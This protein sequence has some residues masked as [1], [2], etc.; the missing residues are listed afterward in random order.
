MKVTRR[1][2]MRAHLFTHLYRYVMGPRKEKGLEET[3]SGV[4][5][6]TRVICEVPVRSR[7]YHTN[8]A[9]FLSCRSAPSAFFR[10]QVLQAPG[11]AT[12]T[13]TGRISNSARVWESSREGP[14]RPIKVAMARSAFLLSLVRGAYAHGR[15]EY[16][17]Q[18]LKSL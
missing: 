14:L 3:V 15:L 16:F 13:C 9:N 4:A 11:P 8:L 7:C 2:L 10:E 1:D 6:V 17:H 5:G 18:A 12:W